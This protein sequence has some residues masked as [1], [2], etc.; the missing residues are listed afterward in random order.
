MP[1]ARLTGSLFANAVTITGPSQIRRALDDA[2]PQIA[3]TSP[4]DGTIVSDPAHVLVKGTSSDGETGAASVQV[5]G[6]PATLAADGTWQ[7]TIDLT[8]SSTATITPM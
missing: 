8:G 7:I 6:H 4:A 2:K 1:N 5:N 3:I